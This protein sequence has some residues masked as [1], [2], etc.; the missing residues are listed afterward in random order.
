MTET[1]LVVDS[2]LVSLVHMN[3]AVDV[4]VKVMF[5]S[6]YTSCDCFL[7]YGYKKKYG[8]GENIWT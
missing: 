3:S 5:Q 7:K 8:V 1:C 4:V 2:V 6:G